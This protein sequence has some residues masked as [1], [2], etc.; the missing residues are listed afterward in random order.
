MGD[1]ARPCFVIWLRWNQPTDPDRNLMI[2]KHDAVLSTHRYVSSASLAQVPVGL[3]G[4]G[5]ALDR[6]EE[7]YAERAAEL[8][9]LNVRPVFAGLRD[10][11]RFTTLLKQMRLSG[12]QIPVAQ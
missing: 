9:W 3:G 4:R 12:S 8:A 7:A 1:K 11:P 10:E 2:L 5:A 6:L